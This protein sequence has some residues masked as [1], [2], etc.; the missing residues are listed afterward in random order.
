MADIIRK[1]LSTF[2]AND[3]VTLLTLHFLG[4]MIYVPRFQLLHK[5]RLR[6]HMGRV[7]P[8]KFRI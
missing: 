7:T 2:I 4:K 5:I 6:L 8:T 3:Q 1:S